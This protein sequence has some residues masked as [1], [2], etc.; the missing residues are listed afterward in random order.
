MRVRHK[1]RINGL[2]MVCLIIYAMFLYISGCSRVISMNKEIRE[3][4]EEIA[5][6][7]QKNDRLRQEI[8]MLESE[9]YVEKVARQDLG[10][11]KPNETLY[12]I[13]K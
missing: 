8:V 5:V 1:Q 3:T 4:Q 7:A 13:I 6:W 12:F 10:L 11:V 9:D 2:L